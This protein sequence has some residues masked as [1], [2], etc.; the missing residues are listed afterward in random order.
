VIVNVAGLT[1]VGESRDHN[2]DGFLVFDMGLSQELPEPESEH[3]LD[4]RPLLLAVSDGM[5]GALAGEVASALTLNVLRDRAT[6]AMALLGGHDATALESWMAEGIHEANRRVREAAS[7]DPT[8]EG[9]GATATS[10]LVFPGAIVLAHV[11]D[12]RAYHLRDG[13]LR[14]IT[15]DHTFVGHLVAQGHLSPEEAQ[16]HEHRHVLLQAVGVKEALEV[17]SLTVILRPDDRLLL[18]SD[19]LYDLV[20]DEA[21]AETLAGE[22]QTPLAQCRALITAANSLGGF[23][24]TTVIILHVGQG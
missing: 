1:D 15:T 19:G 11:G 18:C 10:G 9:M 4:Q 6:G 13:Q 2:E 24:N 7:Q 14:Q 21:I 3:P 5:G 23:D 20:S 17:D 12:S 22:G 16:T 8:I